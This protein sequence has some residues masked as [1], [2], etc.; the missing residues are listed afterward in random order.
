V[1]R[2][3]RRE[4]LTVAERGVDGVLEVRVRV[5]EA[6]QD[7][8]SREVLAAAELVAR[9]DRLDPAVADGDGAVADGRALDGQDP[10]GRE[11]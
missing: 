2:E 5:D 8:G 10:V 11:N 7:R 1:R 4:R 9:P 3:P 6:R